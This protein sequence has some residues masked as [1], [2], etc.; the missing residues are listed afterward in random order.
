MKFSSLITILLI[1]CF[2]SCDGR[3]RANKS[4]KENL[5]ESKLSYPFF[6]SITYIPKQYIETITDT[7]LSSGLRVNIKYYSLLNKTVTFEHTVNKNQI[8]KE[9]YRQFESQITVFKKDK[10]LFTEILNTSDFIEIDNPTFW[11][12]T[13]LQFVWLDELESNEEQVQIYCS[14]L[15]P[16]TKAYKFYKIYY[17]TIGDRRIELIESS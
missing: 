6:E 3:D 13:I 5:V 9:C 17:N 14:F 2:T 11:N 7:I 4:N 16:N 8:V 12:N 1:I 10:L 15:V